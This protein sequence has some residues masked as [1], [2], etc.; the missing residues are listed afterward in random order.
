MM[1]RSVMPHRGLCRAALV[2]AVV[3]ATMTKGAAGQEDGDNSRFR[4]A[5]ELG[6]LRLD[7]GPFG[8]PPAL[9]VGVGLR[10]SLKPHK[11]AGHAA[12]ELQASYLLA[13]GNWVPQV[14]AFDAT[15]V[16]GIPT[17]PSDGSTPNPFVSVGIGGANFISGGTTWEAY[18]NVGAT[19]CVGRDRFRTG[20][21]GWVTVGTGLEMDLGGWLPGRVH[22]Q[23][24]FPVPR[25]AEERERW[26][27][28]VGLAW[29]IG[30]G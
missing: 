21:R 6:F 27:L 17:V 18:C 12:I 8:A 16:A 14:A 23:L 15:L 4:T 22:G 5:I 25:F 30:G 10:G 3:L 19:E 28:R 20:W 29:W 1:G 24:V 7:N 26:Y 9:T 13:L 11:F 2:V